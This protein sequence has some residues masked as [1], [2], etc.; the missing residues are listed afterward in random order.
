MKKILREYKEIAASRELKERIKKIME[1]ERKKTGRN[2]IFKWAI[3][4]AAC[5]TLAIVISLNVFP[6]AAY[7]LYDIPVLSS[8]VRVVT[9]GQYEKKDGGYEAKITTPAVEGLLDKELEDK[10]NKEFKH[11][12]NALIAAYESDVKELK[13]EFGDE[14]V[15]MGIESDY[16]IRT[17][18]ENIL[19]LDVYIL[20]L[21]G[22]SS[23]IHTFYTINKKTNELLTLKGLFEDGADYVTP[24][25]E[26]IKAQMLYENEHNDGF[27]WIGDEFADSFESIDEEQNFYI[28]DDDDIVIC[29]DKYE[30]AAGAQG[31]PEFVIPKD[32][33]KNIYKGI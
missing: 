14:I 4:C 10:L 31:C 17:D 5:F 12:A 29:F 7:A 3:G 6:S 13:K 33:I 30:V 22:S 24:I 28:N 11:N 8:I 20:S 27:F 1:N 9:F 2:N 21:A 19:A 25:S 15:H 32:I 23:T 26:Y 18:N 16:V